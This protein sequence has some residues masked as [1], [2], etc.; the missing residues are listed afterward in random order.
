MGE[1]VFVGLLSV[2]QEYKV[3][4]G[5]TVWVE[6]QLE[7]K[8]VSPAKVL[9]RRDK[10]VKVAKDFIFVVGVVEGRKYVFRALR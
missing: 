6:T 7:D 3:M 2:G 9:M 10:K 4:V 8:V 5:S 1:T